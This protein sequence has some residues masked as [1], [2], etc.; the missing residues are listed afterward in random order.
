MGQ[1]QESSESIFLGF[2]EN[3]HVLEPVR[4]TQQRPDGDDQQV[5]ELVELGA[6]E[7]RVWKLLKEAQEIETGGRL[8]CVIWHPKHLSKLLIK[9][10]LW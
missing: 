9:A 7:P 2:A 4:H 6:F 3:H 5:F 8:G 1:F 10:Q